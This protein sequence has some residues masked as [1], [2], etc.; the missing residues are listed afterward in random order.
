MIGC[1]RRKSSIHKERPELFYVAIFAPDFPKQTLECLYREGRACD[2]LGPGPTCDHMNDKPP[3]ASRIVRFGIFDGENERVATL[4]FDLDTSLLHGSG[5]ED[6]RA[7]AVSAVTNFGEG[8]GDDPDALTK[9]LDA[10]VRPLGLTARSIGDSDLTMDF[11]VDFPTGLTV[12]RSH[13]DA[14]VPQLA[15]GIQKLIAES[16]ERAEAKLADDVAGRIEALLGDP[17][18]AAAALSA[19]HKDGSLNFRPTERLGDVACRIDVEALSDEAA[20]NLTTLRCAILTRLG[21]FKDASHDA[22]LLLG[23]WTDHR[24]ELTIEF[25]NIEA[26][27]HAKA[28]RSESAISIW[29]ELAYRTPGI[30]ANQRA[31][32]LR[33]MAKTPAPNDP[34]ALEWIEQSTDA[35]L[36]AGDR[37]EA[38]VNYVFWGEMLEHHDALKAVKMID[39]AEVV[40]D[41]P[42]LV[43][44]ALRAALFYVRASRLEALGRPPE[45]LDAAIA[46]VEG[47]RGLIGQEE[48]L[49]ASLALAESLARSLGDQ[50][51]E[52]LAAES[53][54]LLKEVPIER[55]TLGVKI[56]RLIDGW[57]PVIAEQVRAAVTNTND[58]IVEIGAETTLAVY[59]PSLAAE[60]RLA[61]LE[62][63]HTR[64]AEKDVPG[65]ALTPIRL[66]IAGTLRDQDAAE[67]A[68]PWLEA[69]L[70]D[71]PLAAGVARMLIDT[72]RR[73]GAFGAVAVVARR[74]LTLKGED[75]GR[76]MSFA[77]LALKAGS[78]N[79]GLCA[80]LAASRLARDG[81]EKTASH[82]LMEKALSDGG[83]LAEATTQPAVVPVTANAFH[84]ALLGFRRKVSSDYRMDYWQKPQGEVHKWVSHPERRAQVQLR[85]WLDAKF[86]G[87]VTTLEEISTGAG[88]LDLLVQLAGGT[89]VILELKM[90]GGRYSRNYA[91]EGEEQI[92]HYMENRGVRLGYLVVF[93]ARV[94][95]NGDPLLTAADAGT[96]TVREMLIDVRPKVKG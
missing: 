6:I 39:G 3:S 13:A 74:E 44:D 77:D 58:P 11:Q 15:V 84:E 53:D 38:A 91:E 47:R 66:A 95:E 73:E 48:E 78:T 29:L 9:V 30:D 68:V 81:A 5:G 25:R 28:G 27:A 51:A 31:Q 43:A 63:L 36:Q 35:Y 90:L 70:V 2:R 50:R 22:K 7:A 40:L 79:E 1:T 93:D 72:L 16:I 26:V 32:I 20:R 46:S 64:F 96:S 75:Y 14:G 56:D 19:A 12:G 60:A 87:R 54:Q 52:S 23:R 62:G 59:D 4:T 34:R 88:R 94:R 69:I 10:A 37:R 45:A 17:E 18:A 71:A 61:R 76:L 86:E 65:A 85:T 55:F 41:E 57:D 80:A 21:R 24:P 33:N 8:Q 49:L 67:R 89:Q 83:N 42:G 82:E 92:L